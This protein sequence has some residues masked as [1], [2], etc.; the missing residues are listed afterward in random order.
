MVMLLV[1]ETSVGAHCFFETELSTIY[2]ARL[3]EGWT[4]VLLEPYLS[5]A[6]PRLRLRRLA[7]RQRMFCGVVT[8]VVA[9]KLTVVYFPLFPDAAQ[10]DLTIASRTISPR[11]PTT[12]CN[13]L[14]PNRKNYD[15]PNQERNPDMPHL[16]TSQC[17]D[18]HNAEHTGLNVTL[19]FRILLEI[20]LE[21]HLLK[22]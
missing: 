13:K 9:H 18:F 12:V 10:S 14:Q 8:P 21:I 7:G 11:F 1:A 20:R 6:V 16:S 3:H 2:A 5:Y 15:D 4:V 19:T 22:R 17:S